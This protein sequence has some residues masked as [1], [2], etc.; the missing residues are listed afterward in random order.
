MYEGKH[1]QID[2][3]AIG[4]PPPLDDGLEGI[5][6]WQGIPETAFDLRE[7][8]GVGVYLCNSCEHYVVFCTSGRDGIEDNCGGDDACVAVGLGGRKMLVRAPNLTRDQI[9]RLLRGEVGGEFTSGIETVCKC[10]S[11]E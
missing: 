1:L 2:V 5:L 10:F 6:R 3:P 8:F 9:N 7:R 11:D 4:S